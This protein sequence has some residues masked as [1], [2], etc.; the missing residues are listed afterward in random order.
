M[1]ESMIEWR[2]EK[3]T[4]ALDK[5]YM[6]GRMSTAIYERKSKA[7]DRWARLQ[8]RAMKRK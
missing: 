5:E 4:D 1:T 8:Y 2:V 7:I 3:L 6:A